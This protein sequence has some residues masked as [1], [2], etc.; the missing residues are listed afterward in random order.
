MRFDR[1][2]GW[3]V[4]V[5]LLMPGVGDAYAITSE[6]ELDAYLPRESALEALK[7]KI[8]MEP[9]NHENYYSC[10]QM[11]TML[12]K[13]EDAAWCY[14]RLL[15]VDPAQ[16]RARLDLAL[17]YVSLARYDDA[18]KM[19]NGVLAKNP[20]E[21]VKKNIN[22]VLAKI[23]EATRK[24]F[25]SGSL[26]VGTA[27]DSNANAAPNSGNI[28]VLDTTV[29]LGEGAMSR[30]DIQ[31]FTAATATHAYVVGKVSPNAG[32]RWQ[33][34]AIAYLTR[35]HALPQLNLQLYGLRTGPEFI[36]QPWDTRVG[37]T[38]GYNHLLLDSQ[39]YLRNPSIEAMVDFP[40]HGKLRGFVQAH[41]EYRDFLNSRAVSTYADRT[42]QARQAQVGLK[43]QISPNQLLE[44][45][46][47]LRQEEAEQNYYANS[48][49]GVLLADTYN[50]TSDV[51]GPWLDGFFISARA[52]YKESFYDASDPLV[53][54]KKRNDAEH[55]F[56]LML[57]RKLPYD[58]LI[59][60]A[61]AY[62]NV[63]SNIE[64]YRYRNHRYALT[65]TKNF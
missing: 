36:Y 63:L 32:M 24:H 58:S 22:G 16:D 2:C 17:V 5:A 19:L 13:H 43:H 60:G 56:Q 15:T 48:Q 30:G 10:A 61:Y 3:V 47:T 49:A 6:Y 44:L 57:G 23:D 41:W 25:L 33:S 31:K 40:V 35:Q 18:R 29:P 1:W 37:V 7:Q 65:L 26:T 50:F 42:G 38:A 4:I 27:S 11:A 52:G 28:L 45:I 55:S 51:A 8:R 62:T 39:S 46:A 54:F 59:T 9:G 64:N 53:S 14:E 34:N 21:T 20:P 12:G